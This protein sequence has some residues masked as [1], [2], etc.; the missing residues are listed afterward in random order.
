M[1]RKRTGGHPAPDRE[2][3]RC[4]RPKRKAFLIR[5]QFRVTTNAFC[6]TV[7][8]ARAAIAT[9]ALRAGA[10]GKATAGTLLGAVSGLKIP[11]GPR[12]RFDIPVKRDVAVKALRKSGSLMLADTRL[13]VWIRTKKGEL[14]TARDGRIAI[15]ASRLAAVGGPGGGKR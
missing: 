15:S 6:G 7:C 5:V 13:Q 14:V 8:N 3:G 1:E 9:K 10:G 4:R 2:S 11:V 12:V